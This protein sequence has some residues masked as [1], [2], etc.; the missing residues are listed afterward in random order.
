[1]EKT[2]YVG[3]VFNHRGT[4]SDLIVDRVR[5]CTGKMI[6]IL[7]LCEES[8]LG[9]YTVQSAILLYKTMFVQMLIFNCQGWSH[10]TQENLSTLQRLQ[11][12]FLNLILWLPLSTS[13]TFIFLE[14]GILPLSHE[15]LSFFL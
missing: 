5:K 13:N 8:G 4:N 1:M 9:R 14:F 2:K 3:D 10:L 7:A 15:I 11:L 6:S 12:K